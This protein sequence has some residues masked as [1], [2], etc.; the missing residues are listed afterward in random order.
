MGVLDGKTAVI[1][2][3]SRGLGEAMAVGYAQEGA[4]LM[5]ASRS[6]T[7]LDR[8]AGQCRA[9][10]AAAVEVVPTDITDEPQ[11][12]ALVRAALDRLGGVDVFVANAGVA[13]PGL[14]DKRY[15]TLD[16]YELDVVEELFRVNAIGMWL[17]MKAALPVMTAG[18]SFIA[19]GSEVGRIARAGSGVY[20]VT[21]NC[22]DVLTTIASAEMAEAQVRVNCLTPGG[23]VDTYLFGPNKMPDAIKQRVPYSEP[24]VIVPAAIWLASDDSIGV[25]GAQIAGKDFNTQPASVTKA[26]LVG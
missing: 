4:S 1:T 21:K 24:D 16:T 11:V 3:A 20:A 19:V 26:A 17:C 8:V 5:L 15:T 12:Q 22:V 7:D 14:T 18:G 23:M 13:V 9:A 10:G 25:T 2:G 6:A